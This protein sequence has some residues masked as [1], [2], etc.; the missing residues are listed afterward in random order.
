MVDSRRSVWNDRYMSQLAVHTLP[1]DLQS[2]PDPYPWLGDLREA[3]PVQR[4]RMRGEIEAWIVTRYDDVLAGITDPRLSSDPANAGAAIR[5]SPAFRRRDDDELG[6]SMLSTRPARP[7]P[8][9]P[10]G[11][12]GV[13]RPPRRGPAPA[14]AGDRRRAARRDARPRRRVDLIDDFAFP[15]PDHGH[16]RA[17]RRPGRRPRQFRALVDDAAVAADRRRGTRPLAATSAMAA[18]PA[19]A[20]ADKRRGRG[21]DL[22]TA[23]IH[24]EEEGDRSHRRRAARRWRS[25][26][27][28]PATRR[29]ST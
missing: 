13:H 19:R 24:A 2:W 5:E 4:I 15:L 3:G 26:C 18:L 9:A 23:L 11:A 25:C 28:S 1:V 6:I 14:D 27:S 10:A 20:V 8:A 17:A 12:E 29:P 7:H 16:L 22:L 21:D